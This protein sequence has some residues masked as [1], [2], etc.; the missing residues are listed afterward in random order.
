MANYRK[1]RRE[2]TLFVS[3]S[4]EQLL[5]A[6]SVAR[7]I[8]EGLER[9]DFAAFDAHYRNDVAGRSAINP[10]YL[11]AVLVLGLLRG[12]TSSLRLAQLCREDIEFRWLIGDVGVE[13]TT[14]CDFRKT[15]K[16]ELVS[17][18]T[19]LLAALGEHGLLPGEHLGV[20][21][22]IVRAAAS[23]RS[24]KSRRRLERHN[25]HLEAAI[26]ERLAHD[27]CD[28]SSKQAHALEKRR[29]RVQQALEAMTARGL[30][31]ESA[32]LTVTEP[33]ATL[34]RQKDGTFAP[35]YNAQVV[36]D[37]S[38]G[39]VIRTE[40][41]DSSGDGG[42]LQPQ[43]EGAQEAL[44]DSGAS[45]HETRSVTADAAYHDTRQLVELEG[46]GLRCYVPEDRNAKRQVP[47]VSPQF[48]AEA[49]VYDEHNDTM[50]CPQGQRLSRRKLN[51]TKTAIVYQA[52]GRVCQN[53][54]FKP[55]CCPKSKSGRSVNRPLY[56]ETLDTV[57]KRMETPAGQSMRRAR[58]V[59]C[60]GAFARLNILLHWGRC[61][62]WNWRGAEMEL[63]WRQ[64]TH[65]LMLLTGLWKPLVPQARIA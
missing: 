57:A 32:R 5:S 33:D 4:L 6:N 27:D 9:L 42:Q 63:L 48:L 7:V 38:S 29:R 22:T 49:F 23:R 36:T 50:A 25:K 2:S 58:Q 62:M 24:V 51:N 14:L 41:V 43:L 19:Q 61:R 47:G 28:S 11:A 18:S 45:G 59:V 12:V 46:R 34:K 26:A 65:N 35:G 64:L 55:Q 20:D 1:D 3:G 60:E 15:H 8:R 13:K 54:P 10:R 30:E 52:R 31:E 39:A 40:L 16:P 44:D 56:R 21:G 53:C 17:L 37:L